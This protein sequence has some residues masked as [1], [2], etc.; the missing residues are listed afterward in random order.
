MA[1]LKV[2]IHF[3]YREKSHVDNPE[4]YSSRSRSAFA[5]EAKRKSEVEESRVE[6]ELLAIVEYLEAERDKLLGAEVPVYELTE[7]E[8]KLGLELLNKSSAF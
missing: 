7:D 5:L 6:K 4:L 3:R 2:N 8:R 1:S